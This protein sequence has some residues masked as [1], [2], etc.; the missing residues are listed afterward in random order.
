MCA[1]KVV[2]DLVIVTVDNVSLIVSKSLV[3]NKLKYDQL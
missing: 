3:I 2:I 1:F